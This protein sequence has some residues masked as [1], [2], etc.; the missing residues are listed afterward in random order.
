M[1]RK[2]LLKKFDKI[3]STGKLNFRLEIS[4]KHL[5]IEKRDSILIS[6]RKNVL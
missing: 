3:I 6:Q 4:K 5:T 1:S 2:E